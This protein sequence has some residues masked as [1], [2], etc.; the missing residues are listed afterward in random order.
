MAHVAAIKS[1]GCPRDVRRSQAQYIK[2]VLAR[3]FP[4]SEKAGDTTV[5]LIGARGARE[6]SECECGRG[7]FVPPPFK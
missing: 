6:K 4:V 2:V 3:T 7:F 5:V 1:S